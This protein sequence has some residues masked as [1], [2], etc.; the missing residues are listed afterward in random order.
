MLKTFEEQVKEIKHCA[1]C[2]IYGME[3]HKV[4]YLKH[5]SNFDTI[6]NS[7]RTADN[8]DRLGEAYHK[9]ITAAI[10]CGYSD[11]EIIAGIMQNKDQNDKF[12]VNIE[13]VI[14]SLI[15]IKS[16]V[17]LSES[18]KPVEHKPI[19]TKDMPKQKEKEESK[20]V[21]TD[22]SVGGLKFADKIVN[23][24]TN[25]INYVDSVI[26]KV[27]TGKS[28]DVVTDISKIKSVAKEVEE[29]VASINPTS[30]TEENIS[31][32]NDA[33]A[34][35]KDAIKKAESLE[36]DKQVDEKKQSSV[37][38]NAPVQQQEAAQSIGFNIANFIKE[39]QQ[40]VKGPNMPVNTN[41][42]QAQQPKP[43]TVFPH[44]ICG[45]SDT[46]IVEEVRKHFK[47]FQELPA[48]PL[49]DLANNKL[50]ARKMKE[51]DAKQRP[52]NPLLTQVNINEYI[53]VPELLSQYQ[54]CFT[55]PCNDKK[56]VIVVLFNPNPVEDKNGVKQ[57][58][59]HILKAAKT[60]T[61]NK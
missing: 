48:Y 19:E 12:N 7:M 45:L 61:N 32:L 3:N 41:N 31:I 5:D 53:D 16:P 28:E 50:L 2:A 15:C 33:T 49:Y 36:A 22:E 4:T 24:I 57:Y 11:G 58:P 40:P 51:M 14:K 39:N 1:D 60:N 42:K 29:M 10:N 37:N 59:L 6:I 21:K 23:K 44:Q 18:V 25:K 38:E 20:S 35:A 43:T 56:Q 34:S 30:C 47:V 17:I 52:N 27:E 13:S 8:K 26:S 54:L 55:M 9:Y 46:E